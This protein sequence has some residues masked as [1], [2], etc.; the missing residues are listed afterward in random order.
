MVPPHSSQIFVYA[1][2]FENLLQD[3]CPFCIF[4]ICLHFLYQYTF[5]N[6]LIYH[7][8]ARILVPDK[9]VFLRSSLYT[10]W[11]NITKRNLHCFVLLYTIFIIPL[12]SCKL[13]RYYVSDLISWKIFVNDFNSTVNFPFLIFSFLSANAKL[14]FPHNVF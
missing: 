11:Q 10:I 7:L 14:H 4:F 3:F 2:S 5:W 9:W 1:N 6:F 13:L 12:C 8:G